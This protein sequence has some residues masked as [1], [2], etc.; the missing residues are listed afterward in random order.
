MLAQHPHI[1]RP[2]DRIGVCFGYRVGIA[3]LPAVQRLIRD[4]DSILD[5]IQKLEARDANS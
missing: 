4:R 3:L 2:A 5:R 1:A